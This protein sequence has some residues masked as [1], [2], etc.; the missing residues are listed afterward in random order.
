MGSLLGVLPSFD[1]FNFNQLRPSDPSNPC[2]DTVEKLKFMQHLVHGIAICNYF[3]LSSSEKFLTAFPLQLRP[4]RAATEH[5]I[6]EH[7]CKQA[8]ASTT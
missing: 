5:L 4:K 1:P 2:M 8:K 3:F 7:G 6:P